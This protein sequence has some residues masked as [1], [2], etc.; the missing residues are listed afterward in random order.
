L[1]HGS[2]S[3]FEVASHCCYQKQ[4]QWVATML[5]ME[6]KGTILSIQSAFT[7]DAREQ[8]WRE[9]LMEDQFELMWYYGGYSEALAN[10]VGVIEQ[11]CQ[12]TKAV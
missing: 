6:E 1:N 4:Q 10:G 7:R 3:F 8:H 12:P 2:S 9:T 5:T 11:P